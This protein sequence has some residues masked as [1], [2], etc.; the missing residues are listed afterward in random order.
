MTKFLLSAQLVLGVFAS[1]I[2]MW[3][4]RYREC[5]ADTGGANLAGRQKMIAALERLKLNHEQATLPKSVA[6]F[7]ISGGGGLVST[8][9]DLARLLRATVR[10]TVFAHVSTAAAMRAF[11]TPRGPA[12]RQ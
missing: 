2:V 11:R 10:G 1:M 4:S 9:P 6:A 3:S 8:L 5:H 12:M 7:G